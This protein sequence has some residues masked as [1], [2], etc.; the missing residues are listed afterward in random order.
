ML[1][2]LKNKK[3]EGYIDIAV[4][5]LV[6]VFLLVFSVGIF[7]KI[8]V[9]QDLTHMCHELVEAATASGRI[10]PEVEERF[11]Q[12]CAE[13]GFVPNVSFSAVYFDSSS[14][15]VQ[16]G[17]VITCTL[18]YSTELMGFGGFSLPF[19][20]EVTESGLSRIYWK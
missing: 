5:V 18:T 17:D 7:S 14:G 20:V 8:A 1:K 19:D 13:A 10:G 6:I 11:E 15:K 12:L 3:A 9:K 16:L 2:L 4:T